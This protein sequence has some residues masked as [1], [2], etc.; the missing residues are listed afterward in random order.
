MMAET[1]LPLG[2]FPLEIYKNIA[3]HE[4][5]SINGLARSCKRLA[6]YVRAEG[7]D[8]ATSYVELV[9][10]PGPVRHRF[11]RGY[12]LPN[13]LRH[14]H[15]QMH[16]K[17]I[18]EKYSVIVN[19]DRGRMLWWHIACSTLKCFSAKYGRAGSHV[20]LETY[21][22]ANEGLVKFVRAEYTEGYFI[23]NLT[24]SMEV[25][26]ANL[27]MGAPRFPTMTKPVGYLVDGEYHH[28]VVEKWMLALISQ[29]V[30]GKT[31]VPRRFNDP[32]TKGFQLHLPD[33]F[34]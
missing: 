23:A 9:D 33:L 17:H 4:F 18:G 6:D 10:M 31:P 11:Y 27:N 7:R 2:I 14:L 1:L 16:S 22:D 24:P 26:V 12:I 5:G 19:Y 34:Y 25:I 30:V 21:D 29:Y 20:W 32:W 13:G 28:D 8:L 3:E 15:A